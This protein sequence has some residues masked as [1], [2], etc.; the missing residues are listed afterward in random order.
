M[1]K[2]CLVI[3]LTALLIMEKNQTVKLEEKVARHRLR[4]ATRSLAVETVE[5]ALVVVAQAAAV[6]LVRMDKERT[7]VM[8]LAT[9]AVAVVARMAALQQQEVMEV[10]VVVVTAVKVPAARGVVREGLLLGLVLTEG[11]VV[12]EMKPTR[13]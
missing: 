8:R 10:Q 1:Q 2:R 7:E 11:V 3:T 6:L 5:V 12:E 13:R 9:A 4:W